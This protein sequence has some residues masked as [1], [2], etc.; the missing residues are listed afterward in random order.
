MSPFS[1]WRHNAH[2]SVGLRHLLLCKDCVS[3]EEPRNGLIAFLEY[4]KELQVLKWNIGTGHLP[5]TV[6]EG[7]AA[8]ISFF[9]IIF[10]AKL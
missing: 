3:S 1:L 5:V 10:L 6:K 9:H 8:H 4:F 2:K 7:L